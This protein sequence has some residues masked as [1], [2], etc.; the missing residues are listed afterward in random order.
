MRLFRSCALAALLLPAAL[1]AQDF[2][3]YVNSNYAGVNGL[4]LNPSSIVDSRF[5]A[6]IL[7]GGFSFNLTNNYM[8]IKK[9][10][11]ANRVGPLLPPDSTSAWPNFSD[12]DFAK[13][14]LFEDLTGKTNSVF[15]SNQIALPSFMFSINEKNAL[16]LNWKLRTYVN[17]D[18]VEDDLAHQLYSDFKDSTIYLKPLTNKKI[19]IQAQTWAEYGLTYGRTIIDD[20]DKFL[21]V[22]GRVKLLQGFGAAYVFIENLE[23]MTVTDST[24]SLIKSDVNYGHSTNFE[25][26]NDNLA[27]RYTSNPGLGFDFGVTYEW[28]PDWKKYKYDMDGETNLWMR[29]KNKYKL[30]I[31]ASITDIGS[32]KYKKGQLSENFVAD[33][34]NWNFRNINLPDSNI[35]TSIDTLIQN[36]FQQIGNDDEYFRMNLPTAFSAQIDY[37]IWKDFYINFTPYVALQFKNNDT[38]VHEL[39][40]FSLTP[41]WDHKWFGVFVPFSYNQY[42]EFSVGTTVRLGPVIIGTQDI[43]SLLLKKKTIYG[44]DLHFALKVPIMYNRIKDKDKDKVSDKKDLC[45]EVPGVWEFM[46]C[47]DR[48]G[49]HVQDDKD[50]CPDVPGLAEFKGCPDKDGD[51]IIDMKDNCPDEPGL[52]EFNGCPDRDGDKIMDKEDDCPDDAGLAEFKGCPDRDGDKLIDKLDRCPDK[53]GPIDNEG[54]PETLLHLIDNATSQT[55][56]SSSRKSKEGDFFTYPTLPADSV[57]LFKLEGENTNLV[58][59]VTVIVNGVAKKAFR[60]SKDQLF[61]FPQKPKPP[62]PVVL[63]KE[64]EQILKKAFDNL[65]FETG[66]DIIRSSSFA[67]LDEL[68]TLLKK[69]PTW[70]LRI[71]GHTDNVGK[72]AANLKLSEKRAKAVKK[73]LTEKGVADANLIAEWYG[74]TK[75]IASNKTPEGRQKNRRVEMTILD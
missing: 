5:K 51:K 38:K 3:G 73:Y 15:F 75:P 69:K 55:Q 24:I 25:I 72:P 32:I 12:P 53:P 47:P 33:I 45:K 61:R 36:N 74:Q 58:T 46:G 31:G 19:S 62:A 68:A 57:A 7:L 18:G 41:R 35:V 23:Y 11:F 66:K 71:A 67:S 60:D 37:N 17:V 27:Y 6:D 10:A 13:K 20:E 9:D 63:T 48:D 26:D 16:G 14:Y 39:S 50:E 59:E 64:E 56:I 65:E 29:N 1:Q 43:A 8:G 40:T 4:D 22:G 70:K 42:Q 2:L 54:C 34:N 30:K 52:Q 21:K 49:D 44:A 28:R